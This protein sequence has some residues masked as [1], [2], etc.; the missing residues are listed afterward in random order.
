MS[1]NG[2]ALGRTIPNFL[3][4]GQIDFQ[5]GY[6]SLHWHQYWRSVPLASCS[7]QHVLSTEFDLTHYDEY[8]VESQCM[9]DLYFP[10]D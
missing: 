1:R 8:K 3:R 7:L 5:S 4:N 9:L 6:I 2:I 10:D